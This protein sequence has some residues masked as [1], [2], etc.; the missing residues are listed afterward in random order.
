MKAR[1]KPLK[2]LPT[3]QPRPKPPSVRRML[4]MST[5]PLTRLLPLASRKFWW[6]QSIPESKMA[7]PTPLPSRAAGAAAVPVAL[8]RLFTP[9]AACTKLTLRS[10]ARLGLMRTTPRRQLEARY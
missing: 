7:V 4:T 6:R 3:A 5:T 1:T 8:A 2:S 10:V 9:V